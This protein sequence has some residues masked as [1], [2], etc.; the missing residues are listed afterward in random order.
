M[1]KR[2]RRN[3]FSILEMLFLMFY[4]TCFFIAYLKIYNFLFEKV[5]ELKEKVLN[6]N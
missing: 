4:L 2:N 1:E 5:K 3:G 6:E